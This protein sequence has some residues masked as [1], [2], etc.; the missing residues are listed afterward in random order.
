MPPVR[1]FEATLSLTAVHLI[2][3]PHEDHPFG[4]VAAVRAAI[5]AL[6][7]AASVDVEWYGDLPGARAL[8]DRLELLDV[9]PNYA[10]R[11]ATR[12]SVE[13]AATDALMT[14]PRRGRRWRT[15]RR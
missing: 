1:R 3:T 7:G 4:A 12:A 5:L 13:A 11:L 14:A 6:P 2:G 15:D 9:P 8:L 10:G